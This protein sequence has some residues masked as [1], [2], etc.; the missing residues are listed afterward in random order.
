MRLEVQSSNISCQF[1]SGDIQAEART[2]T[3]RHWSHRKPPRPPYPAGSHNNKPSNFGGASRSLPRKFDP[4]RDLSRQQKRRM[5]KLANLLPP[6][7]K[8]N[9]PNREEMSGNQSQNSPEPPESYEELKAEGLRRGNRDGMAANQRLGRIRWHR[10]NGDNPP[11]SRKWRSSRTEDRT[12]K[13]QSVAQKLDKIERNIE[14]GA[15]E[16]REHEQKHLIER[17]TAY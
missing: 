15:Q 2:S 5:K 4:Y 13:M 11:R 14:E 7:S 8:S 12:S 17:R 16:I 1:D 6:P 3:S 10:K 9:N